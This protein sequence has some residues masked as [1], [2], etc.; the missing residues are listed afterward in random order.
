M[1]DF[2]ISSSNYVMSRN[3]F[4]ENRDIAIV[5]PSSCTDPVLR[6]NIPAYYPGWRYCQ[7]PRSTYN[8]NNNLT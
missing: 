7:A 4:K 3:I 6:L 5:M 8:N 1:M 2:Q